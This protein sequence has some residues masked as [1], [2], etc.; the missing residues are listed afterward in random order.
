MDVLNFETKITAVQ[1]H[2]HADNADDSDALP[3]GNAPSCAVLPF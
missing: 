1:T 3:N 2:G